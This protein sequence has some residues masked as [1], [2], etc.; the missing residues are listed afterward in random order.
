MITLT[1]KGLTLNFSD[2]LIPAE[3]SRD[4]P[5]QYINDTDDYKDYFVTPIVGWTQSNGLSKN[6]ICEYTDGIIKIP[7]G[8]FMQSGIILLAI[9]M[10]DPA[11]PSHVEATYSAAANV[12][13]APNAS[14]VLPADDIWQKFISDYMNQYFDSEFDNRI[15]FWIN[16][17]QVTF[18]EW[19]EQIVGKLGSDPAG[20]LQL[21]I[22]EIIGGITKVGNAK[23]ADSV[24][25][26]NIKNKP[27]SYTPTL[28][29]TSST[30]YA[31]NKGKITTDNVDAILAGTKVVPKAKDT[32]MFD[33][34]IPQ[35]YGK[36]TDITA[37]KSEL[38]RNALTFSESTYY[39]TVLMYRSGQVV[40]LRCSGY[41]QKQINANSE[42]TIASASMFPEAYRPGSDLY[43]YAPIANNGELLEV[44]IYADGRITFVSPQTLPTQTPI[45]LHLTYLTG[46]SNF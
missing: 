5:V 39:P 34:H 9:Q 13:K 36:Q 46:K 32:E 12:Q 8:A 26:G 25:W 24:N 29:E 18:D 15:Q 17:N 22:D 35:Y 33:G 2:G 16:E 11:D 20:N 41:T 31:G 44:R 40:Y 43:F 28:G 30:A 27:S 14:I 1:R 7:S 21:Q 19:F 37:I 23:E 42:I 4:V 38:N 45:N 6:S 10:T 3:G